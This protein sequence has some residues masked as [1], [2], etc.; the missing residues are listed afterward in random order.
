[1][2][3]FRRWLKRQGA[4]V[5]AGAITVSGLSGCQTESG[6]VR[7]YS[8]D[9]A[10][11]AEPAPLTVPLPGDGAT[12]SVDSA[13]PQVITPNLPPAVPIAHDEAV[14]TNDVSSDAGKPGR[15]DTGPVTS[16][17]S[18]TTDSPRVPVVDIL[19]PP[20]VGKPEVPPPPP[21]SSI[22]AEEPQSTE[23]V[24]IF[25]PDNSTPVVTTPPAEVSEPISTPEPAVAPA[26]PTV[27]DVAV[28]DV[29]ESDVAVPLIDLPDPDPSAGRLNEPAAV[30]AAE[31]PESETAVPDSV[32]TPVVENPVVAEPVVEEPV[33]EEPDKPVVEFPAAVPVI[34]EDQFVAIEKPD[35]VSSFIGLKPPVDESGTQIVS[36][37][38]LPV[39][40]VIADSDGNL[41]LSQRD[42]ILRLT[43]DGKSQVWSK[44]RAP[45]GHV[46][47]P[48]GS[49]VVCVAGMRTV[50]RLDE[51]GEITEELA[52]GSDGVF[53]RS[54][55]HVVADSHGGFY[56]TDPGYARIRNPIGNVHYIGKDGSVTA[57]AQR[58]A[59]PEGVT[60][61][62]DGSKLYVVES[63]LN[64]VTEFQVLAPGRIGQK[65][66]LARLPKKS[67]RDSDDFA[68]SLASDGN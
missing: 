9:P 27:S 35:P 4:C 38:R 19:D 53:L 14:A 17:P 59:F 63:Q 50:V 13:E 1:M 8:P 60:L 10:P 21:E 28:P 33:V 62:A 58:L 32:P 18:G 40:H 30:P 68:H 64:R 5:V 20:A 16:E 43:P 51:D 47:L 44:L 48:D 46:I 49:H 24:E 34:E 61:S 25:A 39:F 11:A 3:E 29:A 65:R 15:D 22:V 37:Q 54:P 67:N 12:A 55:S 2:M 45:R 36:E 23:P 26:E 42:A 7:T 52:N 57:V 66:V 31:L 41:F 56:F 6:A